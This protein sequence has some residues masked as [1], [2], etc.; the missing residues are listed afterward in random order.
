[1][2]ELL[3]GVVLAAFLFAALMWSIY[4]A[5]T[6]SGR[7]RLNATLLSLTTILGMGT[8]TYSWVDLAMA[9]GSGLVVF[10]LIAVLKD[11]GWGKLLPLVQAGFGVALIMG[12]PWA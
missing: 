9:S 11:P 4:R 12:L 5:V 1:M 6:S 3:I 10:G 7:A 2:V 8:V